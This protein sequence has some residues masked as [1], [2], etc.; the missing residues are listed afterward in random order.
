MVRLSAWLDQLE[1][2]SEFYDGKA[3]FFT[4]SFTVSGMCHIDSLLKECVIYAPCGAEHNQMNPSCKNT[5]QTVCCSGICIWLVKMQK[6]YIFLC[7][8]ICCQTHPSIFWRLSGFGRSKHR[9][10]DSLIGIISDHGRL[11]QLIWRETESFPNQLKDIIRESCAL[12]GASRCDMPKTPQLASFDVDE[13]R[14]YSE[15]L[16]SD[17]THTA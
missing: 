14:L 15:S 9:S 8:I 13:Q 4:N 7:L 6:I 17:Q 3:T 10:P 1:L 11:F 2:C 5:V 16:F 12:L